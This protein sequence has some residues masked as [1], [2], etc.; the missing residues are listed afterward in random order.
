[1]RR[2]TVQHTQLSYKCILPFCNCTPRTL[3]HNT[4]RSD[5]CTSLPLV[6]FAS[7]SH[8][9]STLIGN[10]PVRRRFDCKCVLWCPICRVYEVRWRNQSD[11]SKKEWKKRERMGE[12][13]IFYEKN[14]ISF[15]NLTLHLVRNIR[16]TPPSKP[17]RIWWTSYIVDR[18]DVISS[19]GHLVR[20]ANK[21]DAQ[22][23]NQWTSIEWMMCKMVAASFM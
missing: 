6:V 17:D 11:E 22:T 15:N 7:D 13:M 20:S 5:T 12:W 3:H 23:H 9:R 18:V 14:T 1:M 4:K 10:C 21:I 2:E 19:H 8:G 16:E